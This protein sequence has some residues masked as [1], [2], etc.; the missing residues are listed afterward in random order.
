MFIYRDFPLT[1]IHPGALLAA[2]VANCAADQGA[3]WPMHE[4]I[5]RGM[6]IREWRSG[7]AADYEVFLGYARELSLDTDA[8]R[9]CVESNRHAPTIE[10][11]MREALSKG[12]RSTPSFLVNGQLVVGAQ[13]FGV[14]QQIF[15]S[16]LRQ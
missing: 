5:F 9:A 15:D 10:D 3:F 6:P 16:L 11:D 1:D 13:P 14:W 12:I 8:L 7:S 4:R 2:H